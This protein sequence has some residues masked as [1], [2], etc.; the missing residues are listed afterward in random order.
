[1]SNR[2]PW[3][4]YFMRI[5]HLVAQRSTCTRR[6]VGAI[7]VRDKRI[8]ATGYNGVPTNIAHCEEVGCLR[9]K[10]NIP[11]GERHEL[12]R[13]LHAE[14]NV[15]IQAATH[16]LDLK[17]CDIYCTTKPCILCTKMLINCEVE[18]IYFSENYPDELSEEM[19][20]EAGVNYVFMEGEFI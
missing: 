15:I 3:P 14:Q 1:M 17:G 20:A 19:L 7:A 18:N 11:S 10:L 13:G 8:L 2:L 9:D 5:A 4:E 6:A 16:Q 12:C